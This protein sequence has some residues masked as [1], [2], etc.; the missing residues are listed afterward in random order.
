MRCCQM[1]KSRNKVNRDA[2]KYRPPAESL[3]MEEGVSTFMGVRYWTRSRWDYRKV[4]W[5]GTFCVYP[6]SEWERIHFE[7]TVIRDADGKVIR[8]IKRK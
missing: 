1:S 2:V 4:Q 5:R 3:H 8:I 7:D 6:V